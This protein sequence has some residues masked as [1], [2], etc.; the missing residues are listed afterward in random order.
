ME[1]RLFCIVFALLA[2]PINGILYA[3]LGDYFGSKVSIQN[4]N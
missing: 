4:F 3:K 2:I 1:G